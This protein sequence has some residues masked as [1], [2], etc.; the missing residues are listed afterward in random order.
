M[1]ETDWSV[2]EPDEDIRWMF[3]AERDQ[4]DE[5]ARRD[6]ARRRRAMW[7]MLLCMTGLVCLAALAFVS[8]SN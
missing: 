5:Q 2:V 1:K 3:D 6:A 4:Y 8:R 7:L